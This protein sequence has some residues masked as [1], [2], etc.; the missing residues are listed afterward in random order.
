MRKYEFLAPDLTKIPNTELIERYC[1]NF[2]Q[3]FEKEK[4]VNVIL[5]K[6]VIKF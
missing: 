3:K 6:K 4:Y 1:E 2:E 5:K